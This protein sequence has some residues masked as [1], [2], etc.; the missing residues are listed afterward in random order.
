MSSNN[1]GLAVGPSSGFD[2]P[3]PSS[4]PRTGYRVKVRSGDGRTYWQN[5]HVAS[6]TEAVRKLAGRGLR[7]LAIE[8][9]SPAVRAR[10]TSRPESFPLVQFSQEL[11]SLL[12]AGLNLNEAIQTLYSKERRPAVRETLSSI[13]SKLSEGQNFSDVLAGQ[14]QQFP[15][16]YVATIRASERT[17]DLPNA[18]ARYI[19][20]QVQV[21]AIRRKLISAA[22]YPVMLLLIGGFVSLFLLGYVVPKFSAVFESSGRTLPWLSWLLLEF[23]RLIHANWLWV[24]AAVVLSLGV[25]GWGFASR[26]FRGWLLNLLLSAP[27][28]A[29]RVEEFRLAR[30][31]RAVSLLLASGIA[32]PRAMGMVGGLLNPQQRLRL[33]ACRLDIEQGQSLSYALT[34]NSLATA[35]AESLVKVGERSGQMAEMLERAARFNDDEFARWVDIASRLLEPLLMIVIGLVIGG[36]VV[37]MYLPIFELAG[38]L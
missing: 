6:E 1:T 12:E 20:Y 36:V 2:A 34:K 31:Y 15:E 28:L 38:S 9:A 29:Q 17:G 32:L 23:G 27:L 22:I 19:V 13:L 3:D 4:V 30:F 14:G 33:E 8:P 37:L 18:L 35:V 21:E 16:V 11:L 10:G 25:T 26:K 7:V 24:G 5:V